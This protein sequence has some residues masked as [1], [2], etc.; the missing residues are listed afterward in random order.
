MRETHQNVK[1]HTKR[2][3]SSCNLGKDTSNPGNKSLTSRCIKDSNNKKHRIK[4]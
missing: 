3:N 2:I 4:S 1:L